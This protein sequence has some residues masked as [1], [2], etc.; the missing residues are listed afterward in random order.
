MNNMFDNV[1]EVLK[2]DER[3][4]T[5]EGELL[6]N[7]VYESAMKM[8]SNLLKLL[9]QNETTRTRFFTDVDGIA[10]FDKVGFGWVINNR[11]FLP[12]S[13]TRF[14]NK[15]G[16]TNANGGYISTSNDVSLVFPYKDCV[17]EG[18]QTREDQKRREI[19]YNETLAPDE[20][21]RLLYPKVLTNAKKYTADGVEE[22]N[23]IEDSDNLV[24]KGNN[25]IGL[26]SIGKRYN[27]KIK[28]IFIDPPYYF[29]A[30]KPSDTFSYNSNFKL[31]SWLVF[32]KN[33][34]EI[35]HKLL[36]NDGILYMAISDDGA[37]YLKVLTD[38]IFGMENFIADVTWESRKSISSDGLMSENHNHILVYA[39]DKN[40][41]EK[42]S[43][44][45][46]LDI[47]SFVYDDNDG[48]GKYRLEPFDAPAVR[49]NLQY[50][51]KN[52]NTNEEYLP[53]S[54]RHWRTEE[55]TYL[56]LLAEN[57]IRFG[58]NGTAKPQYKAYYSE[59][60]D[61]GKGKASSTIW[62]DV[63]QSI[64]WQ[65]IDTNTN[66][67]KDQFE[68]FG[69]SVFTNPK[70]EDLIKRAIEL[71]TEENDIV[72]DFF[73]G[74][75]TTQAVAMKMNRRFIGFEQMDYIETVSIPRLVKVMQGEQTGISKDVNWQGGGS[76]VY[77]ELAK[78][79]QKYVEDIQT[80]TTDA[81]IVTIWHEMLK[82]GFISYKVNPSDI[83]LEDKEFTE[84][85]LDDKKR[86]LMEMLDKNQLYVNY[87]DMEDE[88]FAVSDA[89]K[90]FTKSFYGE[91]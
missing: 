39:K 17:L 32:M 40:R 9:Y 21:D 31:S 38:D 16:L 90:A 52:P 34:L 29:I 43:F 60:K 46:A 57:R 36:S 28:C 84:L 76:F 8:D 78:L 55:S 27:G 56:K 26:S 86:F 41:I 19:F 42:N 67:T 63:K 5:A 10:V 45:L 6:R 18:G 79:N 53:P 11:S 88:T 62:H 64:I 35:S 68:L 1:L 82:T 12:D 73:M 87:C 25:L 7:A 81:D 49:K 3:F 54:G 2:Q 30:T 15:V 65:E 13:Y 74:S 72:L 14:K 4:L 20:V 71:A 83:D 59:V 70:P 23:S 58:V 69:E 24:I 66:A 61:A 85:S 44:R 22:A 89:D 50:V 51:I 48:R 75:A 33:R 47:E 37:H 77:C 80:A 91:M